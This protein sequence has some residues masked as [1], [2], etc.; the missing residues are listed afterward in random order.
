MAGLDTGTQP[1]VTPL[2]AALVQAVGDFCRWCVGADLPVAR[3]WTNAVSRPQ[4][5]YMVVTPFGS[6][7]QSTTTRTYTPGTD[8]TGTLAVARSMSRR[9]QVD[10]YGP[11]AQAQAQAVAT[12]AQDMTGC[13]FFKPYALTPLTVT[14]PQEL[15]GMAGNEQAE[16]RWMV[17][18]TLQPGPEFTGVSVDLDFFDNVNLG[19]HPQA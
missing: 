6:T 4:S 13:D 15:T 19:L 16:P 7:W 3:G 9:V 5:G 18:I 2:D 17:E 8:G 1:V 12:L 14:D 10:F 11:D